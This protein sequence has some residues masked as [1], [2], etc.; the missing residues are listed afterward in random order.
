MEI[1]AG[2]GMRPRARLAVAFAALWSVGLLV[3]AVTLPAYSGSSA[4][5]TADGQPTGSTTSSTLV[6]VNGRGVLVPLAIPLI[7]TVVV[8]TLL[9]L[10]GR[11][12]AAL[13]PWL[14]AAAWLAVA[15]CGALAVLGLLSIGF[16]VLPVAVA[17]GI[18]VAS[19]DRPA[20]ARTIAP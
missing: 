4:G 17:L 16:F 7:A 10:R 11:A 19:S 8:A 1:S 15:A 14:V 20:P 13:L 18:A 6:E 9:L 2:V 12:A 5:T 3:G